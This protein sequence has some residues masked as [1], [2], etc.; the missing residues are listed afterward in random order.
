MGQEVTG[1]SR[2]ELGFW[3]EKQIGPELQK[4]AIAFD[5][6][7]LMVQSIKVDLTQFI[8]RHEETLA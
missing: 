7:M 1:K 6:V 2:S 4:S 5:G 3:A 8:K